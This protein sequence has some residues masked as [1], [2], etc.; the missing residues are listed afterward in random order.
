M[1]LEAGLTVLPS[2]WCPR[3]QRYRTFEV[4]VSDE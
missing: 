2:T 1:E 3:C 4:E